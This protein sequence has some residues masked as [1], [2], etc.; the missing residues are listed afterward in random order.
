[1]VG[2]RPDRLLDYARFEAL[3]TS[4]GFDTGSAPQSR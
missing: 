1:M 2:F 4:L 3:A